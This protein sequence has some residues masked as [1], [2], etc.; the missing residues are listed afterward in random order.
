M[1]VRPIPLLAQVC[2]DEFALR[3]I[4]RV[5]QAGLIFTI[6]ELVRRLVAAQG[7]AGGRHGGVGRR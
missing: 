5:V 7:R 4:A 2:A 3:R 6:G 1:M